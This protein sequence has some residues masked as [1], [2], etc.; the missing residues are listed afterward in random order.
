ME[1]KHGHAHVRDIAKALK[2]KMPSVSQALRK[3]KKAGLVYY[4]RYCSVTL[5]TKG[6]ALGQKVSQRHRVIFKFL[7]DVLK[8]DTKIAEQDACRIEHVISQKTLTKLQTY[9]Q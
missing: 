6:R 4:S 5:T 1:Q 8:V 3:L 9:L 7:H 2:I